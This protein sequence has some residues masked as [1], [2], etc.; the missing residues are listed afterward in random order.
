M[1]YLSQFLIENN[2]EQCQNHH[3]SDV[4]SILFSSESKPKNELKASC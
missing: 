1:R 2:R 4:L 3:Y